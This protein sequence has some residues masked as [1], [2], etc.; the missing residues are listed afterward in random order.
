MAVAFLLEGDSLVEDNLAA[1]ACLL[2][3]ED[4]GKALA[5]NLVVAFLLD[6]PEGDS[7]VEDNLA[8]VA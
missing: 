8:A 3:E 6:S 5:D 1:V 2:E 7:L 4:R